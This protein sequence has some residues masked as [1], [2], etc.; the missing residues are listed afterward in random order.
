MVAKPK[1]RYQAGGVVGG[2]PGAEHYQP[3][4]T[5]E[6]YSA[7]DPTAGARWF[8]PKADRDRMQ[9]QIDQDA[10]SNTA[11]TGKAK[12]GPVKKVV[13]GYQHGGVVRDT[14]PGAASAS[15]H[16]WSANI[17]G[18]DVAMKNKGGKVNKVKGKK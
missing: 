12:G 16:K 8:A 4:S 2:S 15:S 9:S 1:R 7:F 17:A 5:A 10:K 3:G 11:G 13:R 18:R 6:A 14:A